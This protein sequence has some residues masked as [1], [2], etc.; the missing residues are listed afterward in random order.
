MLAY[1]IAE[2]LALKACG[3]NCWQGICPVC[4][5]PNALRLT[6]KDGKLLWHCHACGNSKAIGA[7]LR[8]QYQ[9]Q[10]PAVRRKVIIRPDTNKA[11]FIRKI[12]QQTQPAAG[13]EV[14][15]YLNQRGL[16]GS[17]PPTL[18]YLPNCLHTPTGNRFM[19]MIAAVTLWPSRE[20]IAIHRTYL[21]SDGSGK[22]E[23]PQSRMIL[24]SNNGGAVRLAPHTDK[25]GLAEGIETAL[26]VQQAAGL[27]MWACL[28]TSGLQNLIVPDNIREVVICADHDPP[29][30]KAAYA[31]ADR[32]THFGK[33]VKIALPPRAGYDF[34]D[35]LKDAS[36]D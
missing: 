31:A 15:H 13:T 16:I 19:A 20:V 36:H 12:W 5:Y 2:K 34:N 35:T 24:G 6:E 33:Q 10:L 22:I 26:S 14:E 4:G 32:L 25:L 30:L 21:K 29:G 1:Q 3:N 8:D 9:A 7:F 23:H 28:S 11:A 27:P 17:I 18:R